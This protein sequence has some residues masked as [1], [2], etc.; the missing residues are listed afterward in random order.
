MVHW[1]PA[2]ETA[3]LDL[4]GYNR[5]WIARVEAITHHLID[6]GL[7]APGSGGTAAL[8]IAGVINICLMRHIKEGMPLTEALAR[9]TARFLIRDAAEET[10]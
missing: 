9:D 7:L 6:S 8:A 3:F 5:R 4:A 10:P 1:A 2:G